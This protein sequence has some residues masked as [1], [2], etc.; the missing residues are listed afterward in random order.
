[1]PPE[2][3]FDRPSGWLELVVLFA[4]SAALAAVIVIT[5]S[6]GN[7]SPGSTRR[8]T[9]LRGETTTQCAEGVARVGHVTWVNQNEGLDRLHL[10]MRGRV[11]VLNDANAVFT[12]HGV[13]VKLA[14]G[15]PCTPG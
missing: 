3:E 13:T 11:H 5:S 10:P 2:T 14:P 7:P 4:V 6:P 12:A 1:L 15:M 8:A 9:L